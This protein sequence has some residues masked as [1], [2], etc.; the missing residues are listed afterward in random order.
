M[1]GITKAFFLVSM[2][3]ET[4]T[5]K[6][7]KEYKPETPETSEISFKQSFFGQNVEKCQIE[8]YVILLLLTVIKFLWFW[9]YDVA[10]HSNQIEIE[11]GVFLFLMPQDRPTMCVCVWDSLFMASRV[12]KLLMLHQH[13]YYKTTHHSHQA[14][15]KW[16]R[17]RVRGLRLLSCANNHWIWLGTMR[18]LESGVQGDVRKSVWLILVNSVKSQGVVVWL[19]Y[20]CVWMIVVI[21]CVVFHIIVCQCQSYL[22][23]TSLV[24]FF[25][26]FWSWSQESSLAA[27]QQSGTNP[28][29]DQSLEKAL[30]VMMD[31]H[32]AAIALQEKIMQEIF[33]HAEFETFVTWSGSSV[34]DYKA[35]F[36]E[37]TSTHPE[38]LELQVAKWLSFVQ[39]TDSLGVERLPQEGPTALYYQQILCLLPERSDVYQRHDMFI[40][41]STDFTIKMGRKPFTALNSVKNDWATMQEW[42]KQTDVNAEQIRQELKIA[43]A[44]T[45]WKAFVQWSLQEGAEMSDFESLETLMA[46]DGEEFLNSW[47]TFHAKASTGIDAEMKTEEAKASTSIDVEM[48]TEEAKASTGIDAEMKTEEAERWTVELNVELVSLVTLATPATATTYINESL[49]SRRQR[50]TTAIS[51][52][53]IFPLR[54]IINSNDNANTNDERSHKQQKG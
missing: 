46:C 17:R 30:E 24:S 38:E 41:F 47:K 27:C 42:L 16:S 28:D 1:S 14:Y 50:T 4:L 49:V 3:V 44:D 34:E 53:F 13:S 2:R 35:K 31:E 18:S 26:E 29:A 43:M 7:A 5:W 15:I 6:A 21:V 54:F 33:A 37:T 12:T 48:K 45:H 40:N 9:F 51:F 36:G 22:P 19:L 52:H 8:V 20:W 25:S 32:T 39:S 23:D 11:V 10:R